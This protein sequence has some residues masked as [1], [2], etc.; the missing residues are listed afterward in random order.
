MD[1]HRICHQGAEVV[2]QDSLGQG[3]LLDA[4][5][6][7]HRLEVVVFELLRD[8]LGLHQIPHGYLLRLVRHI[9]DSR[10]SSLDDKLRDLLVQLSLSL[11]QAWILL[12][13]A[14]RIDIL[15]ELVLHL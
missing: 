10:V 9:R 1:I 8:S 14:V 13:H 3:E 11:A 5:L 2:V 15:V 12:I 7:L 6:V 4:A